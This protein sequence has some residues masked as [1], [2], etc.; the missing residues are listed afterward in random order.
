MTRK[1]LLTG[2]VGG[3]AAA[4]LLLGG[5]LAVADTT[6]PVNTPVPPGQVAPPSF[7]DIVQRVAPAVVSI[8]VEGKAQPQETAFQGPQG[9]GDGEDQDPFGNL[10]PEFRHFFQFGPNGPAHP[11]PLRA[12]GSG[13]FVSPDGYIVTNNHVVEGADKITV[14]TNDDRELKATLVGRDPATDLAVV[15]VQ[16]SGYPFVS[17]EDRA[18]PRVGDWV[19]AVGNPFNLGGTATA[20]IVSALARPQISG[21][22]YV[23]YMQID[24]PINRGNSGGPSFDLY[25]RVVGVNSAIFS[26]SGGSVGIGFDIPADVAAQVTKQLIA[27]GK[28]TRGYIGATVQDITPEIADSL[29]VKARSGA[30]VA[31]VTPDGPSAQAGLKSGDLVLSVDGQPITSASDLTRKVGVAHPGDAI[32]LQV[33]RDGHVQELT[34]RSGLRPSERQLAENDL[35]PAAPGAKSGSLGLMVSPNKGGGLTVEQ[36]SPT[37]D[38]AQKGVRPGDVIEQVAGKRVNTAA[39]VHAAVAAAKAEGRKDV[40]VRVAHG[41]QRLYLPLAIGSNNG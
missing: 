4:A 28:V 34:V 17:W 33:R 10:P 27:H 30:L 2:A 18:K 1:E 13:F 16:G 3:V 35:S 11:Q 23:D 9:G 31:D 21:S 40:L 36:V 38:A 6:H 22:G 29:G 24:A 14:R 20:G 12:T 32:R 5:Q 39:D 26:P 15:K 19:V 25:G 41:G 8:D 37:S 7:A